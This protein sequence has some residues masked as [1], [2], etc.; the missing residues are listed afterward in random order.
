MSRCPHC[1]ARGVK[2]RDDLELGSTVVGRDYCGRCGKNWPKDL[3]Q[4]IA[5]DG[6]MPTDEPTGE[7]TDASTRTI[8]AGP[9]GPGHAADA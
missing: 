9:G 5:A 7:E 8:L 6:V 1:G 4:R 2:L 3:A